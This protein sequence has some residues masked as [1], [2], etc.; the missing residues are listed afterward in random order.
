MEATNIPPKMLPRQFQKS[1]RGAAT[2]SPAPS[3]QTASVGAH[4]PADSEAGAASTTGA[5]SVTAQPTRQPANDLSGAS[6]ESLPVLQT[7]KAFLETERRHSRNKMLGL[8]ILCLV[9]LV[10][11]LSAVTASRMTFSRKISGLDTQV[12]DLKKG[13][14]TANSAMDQFEKDA[15]SRIAELTKKAEELDRQ[16]ENGNQAIEAA[17]ASIS[18]TTKDQSDLLDKLG[19]SVETVEEGNAT[20]EKSRLE[21]RALL[22]VVT[23]DLENT[24]REMAS[25]RKLVSEKEPPSAATNKS[26]LP[27]IDLTITPPGG[28]RPINLRLPISE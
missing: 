12:A 24:R 14:G 25:L 23:N 7:F 4:I 28:E 2:V 6:P 27:P 22:S 20:L 10:V 16:V 26:A 13:L 3:S 19:K 9:V 8:M 1:G 11:S 17:S 21:M 5:R 18:S 15:A